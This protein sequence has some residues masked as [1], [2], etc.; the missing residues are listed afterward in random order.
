[1]MMTTDWNNIGVKEGGNNNKEIKYLKFEEGTTIISLR[2]D[3]KCKGRIGKDG[4]RRFDTK[5][6]QKRYT[7]LIH[8]CVALKYI[9]NPDDL[10]EVNHIDGNKLN[11]SIKNLEWVNG[12]QNMKHAYRLGLHPKRK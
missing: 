5:I 6:K 8:R 7:F 2:Y 1:M 12:S 10:P 4:Y 9:P 11:N 3:R